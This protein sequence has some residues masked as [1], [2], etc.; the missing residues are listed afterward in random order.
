M[1]NKK[2]NVFGKI[3][4]GL[5]S[6][7]V[8]GG[9][10]FGMIRLYP[11]VTREAKKIY[12]E[13][14][15]NGDFAVARK[16][17]AK[18]C[19]LFYGFHI[20]Y[21][22][23]LLQDERSAGEILMSAVELT[24]LPDEE[25]Y[26]VW[27]QSMVEHWDNFYEENF[28]NEVREMNLEYG[29]W[30]DQTGTWY[31]TCDS[32]KFTVEHY[33]LVVRVKFRSDGPE[34]IYNSMHLD[35]QD[36]ATAYYDYLV[37][38]ISY[39]GATG[40]GLLDGTV[41]YLAFDEA[42]FDSEWAEEYATYWYRNEVQYESFMKMRDMYAVVAVSAVC[43]A[44]VAGALL[45]LIKPFRIRELKCSN[46]PLE[47]LSA[48]VCLVIMLLMDVMGELLLVTQMSLDYPHSW[49]QWNGPL[50][51]LMA[52]ERE[53]IVLL[54]I[55]AVAWFGILATVYFG[56]V[57]VLQIFYKGVLRFLAENTLIG[58]MI[59]FLVRKVKQ[60]VEKISRIDWKNKGNRKIFFIVLINFLIVLIAGLLVRNGIGVL[61]LLVYS[62]LL[63]LVLRKLWNKT[64]G[65]Y[66]HLLEATEK[67]ASGNTRVCFEGDAGLFSELQEKLQRVQ[68]GF[69]TAVKEE[70]KSQRMK[71]ELITNVSH[72]L[73]TPLTAII[74]Y[75]DLLKNEEI[76]EEERRKYVGV[77]EQKSARLKTLIDDLFEVSK[78]T[79]GD[80]TL[81]LQELDLV[82]LIREV[83]YQLE[84]D[85]MQ[86]GIAFKFSAPEEKVMVYL[87]GQKT[88]RVF[89]NLFVNVMKYGLYGS[90]A[91]VDVEKL[92][93]KVRVTIKN[94]SAGEIT[95]GSGEILDRFTRGDASRNTEGSGLGLAIVKSFVEAQG[96]IVDIQLDGDLF[97]VIIEFPRIETEEP[98][99][100]ELERMVEG[101]V[102]TEPEPMPEELLEEPAPEVTGEQEKPEKDET[103]EETEESDITSEEL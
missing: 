43:I 25:N 24:N 67:M 42:L 17:F 96:G 95:Y 99:V 44:G 22:R 12:S 102:E 59:C 88:C 57:S 65:H 5:L 13:E 82:S 62:L 4:G 45:S 94:V 92:P 100:T 1:E 11:E 78:A 8:I 75:V 23:E 18:A 60:W 55:N 101:P 80:I 84:D 14:L 30:S 83:Q 69:D 93:E 32:Q 77:L 56:V 10:T 26:Q 15:L 58:W 89:E 49:F 46:V 33:P 81:N 6:L 72:D 20:E 71:S 85:I 19:D 7:L 31:G 79:S 54:T 91:F 16:Y 97:K 51:L 41:L 21:S 63:Y 38:Q 29:I 52:G 28:A 37:S 70:V 103:L 76:S 47:I 9:L 34:V 73:K 61:V 2:K 53:G 40:A 86:S 36:I 68:S 27:R 90:R 35:L 39:E 48:L 98:V 66:T 87:D 74:T 50:K 64:R 3:V